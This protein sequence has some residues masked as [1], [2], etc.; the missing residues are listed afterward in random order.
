M[1]ILTVGCSKK[2][3]CTYENN[4]SSYTEKQEIILDFD[5]DIP[6]NMKTTL[7]FSS[8]D[9]DTFN[10]LKENINDVKSN[11]DSSM[12]GTVKENDGS[13]SLIITKKIGKDEKVIEGT[14]DYDN[15][16]KHFIDNGY[17]CK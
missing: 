1:L 2:L 13:I 14:N 3:V 12:N 17:T 11:L 8:D 6:T 15:I 9:E 16:K 5:E 4:A 7:T 10:T